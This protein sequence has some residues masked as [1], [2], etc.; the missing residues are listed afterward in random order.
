MSIVMHTVKSDDDD[1]VGPH[2]IDARGHRQDVPAVQGDAEA[3]VL[4]VSSSDACNGH[5]ATLRAWSPITLH[6]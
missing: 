4:T 6:E 1:G 5:E 3:R 2:D